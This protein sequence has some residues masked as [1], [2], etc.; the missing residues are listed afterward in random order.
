MPSQLEMRP[1]TPIAPVL[2][3][4]DEYCLF[5]DFDGTL[6]D[7]AARPELVRFDTTTLTLISLLRQRLDNAIA[8]VTGREI[9]DIDQFF[10]PL[11]L[12]VAGV[13]GQTRR[14]AFGRIEMG[15]IDHQ[16]IAE[17]TSRLGLFVARE[18]GLLIEPKAGAVAVHYRARPDLEA[19]CHAEASSAVAMHPDLQVVRGTMV[20]EVKSR[21][22]SKGTAVRA[23]MREAPFAGRRPVFA[24]D[25]L[26][27]ED[28]FMAVNAFDGI[29]IKIGPGATTAAYRIARPQQFLAWLHALARTTTGLGRT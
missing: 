28:G 7:I 15:E 8:I 5:L 12:P 16:A 25:D 10:A 14:S 13:H 24:G 20:V 3:Q 17:V 6:V 4:L 29:S 18:P 9:S 1:A 23:F 19:R 11:V 2:G 21:A 26:T 22:F 27:D